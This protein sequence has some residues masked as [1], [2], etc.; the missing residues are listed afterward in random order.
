MRNVFKCLLK[1]LSSEGDER[2]QNENARGKN[3]AGWRK[4][5]DM[6]KEGERWMRDRERGEQGPYVFEIQSTMCSLRTAENNI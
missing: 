6:E 2:R 5:R 4:W 3:R 1:P